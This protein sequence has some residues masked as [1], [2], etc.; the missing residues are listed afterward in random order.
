MAVQI[1]IT[2]QPKN[3]TVSIQPGPITLSTANVNRGDNANCVG[4]SVQGQMVFYQSNPGFEGHD[5]VGYRAIF[6]SRG[7]N[8]SE[9]TVDIT[10]Q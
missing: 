10:V 6:S 9:H 2:N 3:G 7:I 8:T 5:V 1:A 4:R